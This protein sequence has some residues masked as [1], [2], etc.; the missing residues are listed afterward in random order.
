MKSLPMLAP[1]RQRNLG[2][3]NLQA[4]LGYYVSNN[5][6][7]TDTPAIVTGLG[8]FSPRNGH[9]IFTEQYDLV[10]A[11]VAGLTVTAAQI[12]DATYNATNIPQIYPVNLAITPLT[13]P[14]VLDLRDQPWPIPMNEEWQFQISG[15]A[16]GA[17]DDY[18]LIWIVPSG[19]QPWNVS[20]PAP[21]IGSPRVFS[22]FTLTQATTTNIW[23]TTTTIAITNTLKGGVY[24]INGL[25]LV[26]AHALAWRMTFPRH[27]LY[28]GRKLSPVGLVENAYGNV[29]LR[30]GRDWLG[31][32][33][34][35][36][37]FELPQ[38][39]ILASTTEAS[40]TYTGYLDMTYLGNNFPAGTVPGT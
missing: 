40:A 34:M 35:F 14:N 21:T 30:Y 24:Q 6:L 18:A 8:E 27:P 29:P 13:N 23:S 36:N 28:Q 1:K 26:C 39:S 31:M 3:A 9:W 10:A 5:G 20:P 17:E 12:F 7:L 16:G 11:F 32:V 19:T 25:W 15:G 38:M 33:G 4:G 2:R 22:L 37:Y